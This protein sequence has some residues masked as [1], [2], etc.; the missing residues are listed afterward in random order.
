MTKLL[1]RAKSF[2]GWF[3]KKS[4]AFIVL[5]SLTAVSVFGLGVGGTLAATGVIPLPFASTTEEVTQPEP[6]TVFTPK[7]DGTLPKEFQGF[8]GMDQAPKGC[9]DWTNAVWDQACLEA[10]GKRSTALIESG[11]T[12]VKFN[13]ISGGYHWVV[14][15]IPSGGNLDTPTFIAI[16]VSVNGSQ[17]THQAFC[18]H[19]GYGHKGQ[20]CGTEGFGVMGGYGTCLPGGDT[21]LV[22]VTGGGLSF[23]ESG[24]VPAGVIICPSQSPTAEPSQSPTAEPS[25]TPT[26][27][28]SPSATTEPSPSPTAP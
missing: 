24:V 15:G 3:I 7:G 21:Y 10:G 16:Y 4:P 27:E 19:Y 8:T 22:E 11:W 18:Y 12:G 25:Q 20:T 2:W 28:V 9:Y 17:P 26:D 13:F 1:A 14:S 5:T 6:E 23:R